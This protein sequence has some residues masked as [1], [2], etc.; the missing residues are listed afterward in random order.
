M[1]GDATIGGEVAM[2]E[3]QIASVVTPAQPAVAEFV[4]SST[5][6]V[7]FWTDGADVSNFAWE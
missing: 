5:A 1:L 6:A 2:G 4:W 3:A 7:F